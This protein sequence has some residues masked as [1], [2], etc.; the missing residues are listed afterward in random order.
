MPSFQ[1]YIIRCQGNKYT[2][3]YEWSH[4]TALT[5]KASQCCCCTNPFDTP[6][7]LRDTVKS[8][9]QSCNSPQYT[10]NSAILLIFLLHNFV[11]C[12]TLYV[13]ALRP[14]PA[15]YTNWHPSVTDT[16]SPHA[17]V[18]TASLPRSAPRPDSRTASKGPARPS[19]CATCHRTS[20]LCPGADSIARANIE[21][22]AV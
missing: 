13:L 17:R 18:N 6:C 4:V 19:T 10:M 3:H 2:L 7:N 11:S 14:Y 21:C 20:W 15:H 5:R 9:T 12:W 22:F 16:T 8:S 1:L